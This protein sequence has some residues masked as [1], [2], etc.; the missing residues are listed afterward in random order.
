M[1]TYLEGKVSIFVQLLLLK[2]SNVISQKC[3]V[4][5][6]S[7]M[8]NDFGA[9]QLIFYI[10]DIFYTAEYNFLL[11]FELKNTLKISKS[12]FTRCNFCAKLSYSKIEQERRNF[13]LWLK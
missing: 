7:L 3:S 1:K 11:S 2:G 10:G 9:R 13:P 8:A 6:K 4:F 5:V 12:Y